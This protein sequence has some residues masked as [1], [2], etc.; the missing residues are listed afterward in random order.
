MYFRKYDFIREKSATYN[1]KGIDASAN[2]PEKIAALLTDLAGCHKYDNEHIYA[3]MV[4]TKMKIIGF[5]EISSGTLNESITT[6]R[7]VFKTTLVTPDC[8]ALIVAHNHPSGDTTPS[9]PDIELTNKLIKAGDLLGVKL[10][11]HIIISDSGY[12]SIRETSLC[13]F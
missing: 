12:C 7:E 11:D 2:S 9:R 10:L 6:P 3:V 1:A 5:T 8:A 13:E 4:N